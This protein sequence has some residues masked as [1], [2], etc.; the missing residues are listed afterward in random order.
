MPSRSDNST[1]E[2]LLDSIQAVA[3]FVAKQSQLSFNRNRMLQDAVKYELL[4]IGEASKR[5]TSEF[6]EQHPDWP[7]HQMIG[8]RNILTHEYDTVDLG[9]VW[10]TTKRSLPRLAGQVREALGRD[11]AVDSSIEEPDR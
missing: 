7:W 8:L 9:T 6:R 5:F 2:Q 10:L 3:T 11:P 4:V 1:L